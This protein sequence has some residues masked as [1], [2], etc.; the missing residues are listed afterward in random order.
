MNSEALAALSAGT[1]VLLN[2]Q[3]AFAVVEVIPERRGTGVMDPPAERR[4][5]V[6]LPKDSVPDNLSVVEYQSVE[7]SVHNIVDDLSGVVVVVC[8]EKE[9]D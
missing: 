7:L 9:D 4:Y 2:G 3:R 8:G 5:L 1:P 6:T